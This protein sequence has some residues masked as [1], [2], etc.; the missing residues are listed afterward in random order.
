MAPIIEVSDKVLATLDPN[1]YALRP[2]LEKQQIADLDRS[3]WIV[4][5]HEFT[6]GKYSF[7][8]SPERISYCPAVEKVGRQLEINYNNTAKDSLGRDFVGN[9]NWFESLKLNSALGVETLNLKNFNYSANL[10]YLGMQEKINVFDVSG[11]KIDSNVL[12]AY[13]EDIFKAKSPRR[14]EWSDADFKVKGQNLFMDYNHRLKKGNLVPEDSEIL[15]NDT[16]RNYRTLG[17]SLVSWLTNPTNQGLP[18][19]DTKEGDLY[20]CKPV[21]EDNTVAGFGAYSSRAGLY[22]NWNSLFSGSALGVRAAKLR[23]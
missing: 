22:C 20:Y 17:I 15:D 19:K 18:R 10:L 2:D 16:L 5:P 1:V 6:E 7:E 12:R 9:N 14:A 3:D 13:F 21:A 8:F 11:R 23:E 4:V